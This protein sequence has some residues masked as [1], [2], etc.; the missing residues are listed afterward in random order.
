MKVLFPEPRWTGW[1]RVAGTMRR[2]SNKEETTSQRQ[3]KASPSEAP[4]TASP[5]TQR[6]FYVFK[7]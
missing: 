7:E 6:P 5:R 4:H 2:N 1:G 3:V